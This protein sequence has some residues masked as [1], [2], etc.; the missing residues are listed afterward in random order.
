MPMNFE[1]NMLRFYKLL[2]AQTDISILSVTLKLLN[3]NIF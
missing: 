3:Q 2:D 1:Q